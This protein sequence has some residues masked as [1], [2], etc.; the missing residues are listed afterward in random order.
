MRTM[1]RFKL[2]LFGLIVLFL[3]AAA[4][5]TPNK[6]GTGFNTAPSGTYREKLLQNS[7]GGLHL[8][9]ENNTQMISHWSS[10]D[11]GENWIY[12][13]DVAAQ[14]AL[15]TNAV[16][17]STD[18]IY[19]FWSNSSQNLFMASK[20]AGQPFG[21]PQTIYTNANGDSYRFWVAAIDSNNNIHLCALTTMWN[22]TSSNDFMFYT[23]FSPSTGWIGGTGLD[24]DYP[25]IWLNTDNTDDTDYCDIEVD[26]DNNVF[27]VGQ[28]GDQSNIDIWSSLNGFTSS[29]EIKGDWKMSDRP[30]ITISEAGKI[31]V[32][33]HEDNSSTYNINLANSTVSDW[34]SAWT[35]QEIL[36]S[37]GYL[38]PSVEVDSNER[39]YVL[40]YNNSN[41]V[42][43]LANSS[44]GF[45]TWDTGI[46]QYADSWTNKPYA[47]SRGSMYPTFN[48][49]NDSY[50]YFFWNDTDNSHYFDLIDISSE[51]GD[52]PEEPPEEPEEEEPSQTDQC[53]SVMDGITDSFG[54]ASIVI[55]I[56]AAVIIIGLFSSGIGS[57]V[58]I[59][60]LVAGIAAI[61]LLGLFTFIGYYIIAKTQ[62]LI[63]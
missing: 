54:L 26:A 58:D 15:Y 38:Y 44:D 49:I 24:G 1:K 51:V 11:R 48:R 28:G 6:I 8:L 10:S 16:I 21:D 18:G 2:L 25:G 3:S 41:G 9:T 31:Y 33:F 39:A 7:T 30:S 13:G 61:V 47:T 45:A 35:V 43:I 17:N 57:D 32:A 23:N 12:E 55:L 22:S 46:I 50:D 19:V 27:I 4:L 42:V 5:A 37:A 36:I 52:P 60:S 14:T 63:C 40:T 29:H 62:G 59:S 20:P 53:G 34:D 56:L